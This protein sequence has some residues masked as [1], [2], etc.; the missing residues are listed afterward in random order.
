MHQGSEDRW[1]GLLDWALGG[2]AQQRHG[3]TMP[4]TEGSPVGGMTPEETSRGA[5]VALL[6]ALSVT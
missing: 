6:S 5:G 4:E 3:P 2:R 1:A